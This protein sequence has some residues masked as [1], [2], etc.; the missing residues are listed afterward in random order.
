MA[1]LRGA[2]A[3]D[4]DSLTI[5]LVYVCSCT[6]IYFEGVTVTRGVDGYQM[7]R[8][9][10]SNKEKVSQVAREFATDDLTDLL[11]QVQTHYG[12]ALGSLDKEEKFGP[13]PLPPEGQRFRDWKK[14]VEAAGG[15]IH[16]TGDRFWIEVRL[17]KNGVT[18]TFSNHYAKF[19]SDLCGWIEGFGSFPK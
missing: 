9:S 13:M 3:E 17:V 18:N 11:V 6:G 19:P 12:A 1:E 5:A 16:S 8:W 14:A 2:L 10:E 15:Y 7:S 4:W